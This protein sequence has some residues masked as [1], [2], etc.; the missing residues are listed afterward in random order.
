M[1]DEIYKLIEQ[2]KKIA[3]KVLVDMLSDESLSYEQFKN[4]RKEFNDMT[5][6]ISIIKRHVREEGNNYEH[7]R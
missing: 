5:N 6:A 2:L 7:S 4:A 1:S 3:S